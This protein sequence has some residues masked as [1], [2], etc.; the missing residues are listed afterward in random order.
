[1]AGCPYFIANHYLEFIVVAIISLISVKLD[2]INTLGL[3]SEDYKT[4]AILVGAAFITFIFLITVE[5]IILR[6]LYFFIFIFL[7]EGAIHKLTA[8]VGFEHVISDILTSLTTVFV[9]LFLLAIYDKNNNLPFSIYLSVSLVA[10]ILARFGINIVDFLGDHK[11]AIDGIRHIISIIVT[12]FVSVY[13]AY[14]TNRLKEEAERC[15]RNMNSSNLIDKTVAK[16]LDV[17]G[18]VIDLRKLKR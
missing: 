3:G 5:S 2:L 8:I 16:Y 18:Y 9:S 12:F 15:E 1:M 14:D 13:L 10:M 4:E 7:I 17:F 6:Y 11:E